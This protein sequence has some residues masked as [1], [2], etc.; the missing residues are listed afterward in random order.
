MRQELYIVTTTD[1]MNLSMLTIQNDE[2]KEQKPE[3]EKIQAITRNGNNNNNPKKVTASEL[4]FNQLS[5]IYKRILVVDDDPDITLTFKTALEGNND[6]NNKR[7]FEVYTYND[8]ILALSEF[9]PHFYDLMLIDIN[10][11]DLNGFELCERILELDINIKVCFVS[12]VEIN[13]KALREV[14]PKI[15]IG[16]FIQKPVTIDYLVKRVNAELD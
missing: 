2:R 5:A 11:P 3:T 8:P 14:Y 12:A 1:K 9:K 6:D 7:M 10:M 4:N 15:S 16:C 13:D